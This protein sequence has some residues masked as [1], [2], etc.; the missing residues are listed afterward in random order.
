MIAP[1]PQMSLSRQCQLVNLSRSSFYY[2]P[3]PP[4]E[5]DLSLMA[6]IDEIYT[7]NPDFGSRQLR[8]VLDREGIVVNRKRIQRL[9]RLMDIQALYP[10]KTF[11]NQGKG[12]STRSTPIF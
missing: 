1:D 12:Q 11:L 10:K 4:S 9:M 5:K 7:D 3:K 8:N 6:R 2:R